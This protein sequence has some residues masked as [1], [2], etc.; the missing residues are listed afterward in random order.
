MVLQYRK[1]GETHKRKVTITN[2]T[3]D[4]YVKGNATSE[5]SDL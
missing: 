3:G 1:H 4:I 5:A 2:M